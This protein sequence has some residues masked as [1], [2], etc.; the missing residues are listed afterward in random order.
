[1]ATPGSVK[2]KVEGWTPLH[3]VLVLTGLVGGFLAV[4][5]VLEWLREG[6]V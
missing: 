4:C 2:S 5:E 6:H 1:M 3:V